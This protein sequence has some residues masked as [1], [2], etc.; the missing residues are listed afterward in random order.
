[1]KDQISHPN[2]TTGKI[3]VLHILIS[4]SF[5]GEEGK[6]DS[7]QKGSKNSSHFVAF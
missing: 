6:T 1:V 3:M 2:K 7:E 4:G 5:Q